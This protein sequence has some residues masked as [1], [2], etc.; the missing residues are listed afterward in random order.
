MT[1]AKLINHN[2]SPAISINGKVYPPMT[3]TITTCGVLGGLEGRI[4]DHDYF[5]ALGEAGIKIYYIMCNNLDLDKNAVSDFETEANFLLKAVPDAYIIVRFCLHPSEEWCK[6][7]PDEMVTYTDNR[8]IPTNLTA[9][10]C[11]LNLDGMPSLCSQKWRDEMGEVMLKTIKQIKAL[12]CSDHI[13]GYFLAGGGTSEWYYMNDIDFT[14]S[15]A[16]GDV[17]PAFKREFEGYLNEKYGNGV[18][19]PIIPNKEAR[20]YSEHIDTDLASPKIWN[21][22]MAEPKPPLNGTNHGVFVD[23]K[24]NQHTFDF[25][26]AWHLGTA[27]TIIHFAKLIKEN[28]PDT[29]VG[30]FFG[31][32]GSGEVIRGSNAIGVLKILDSGYVDFLANP[33]VYENRQPGGFTGQRQCP[34]SYR[35]R[36]AMFIVEDDTRTNA[37][38]AHHASNYY[39][40]TEND[41][42]NILKRDFGRNIC[43]DLQSWWFDQKIGG[44][45]YKS[46]TI[47]KLF[48]KQQEISQLAYSL[49]RRKNSEIAFIMDEES[50][51]AVS[52]QT[53]NE[54]IEQ[55]RSYD[56]AKIGAPIDSYFHNDLSDPN[57]PDYKLYIFA[58]CLYLSDK[59]R[60]E[61]KAKLRKNNA[62][63]VFLYAGGIINPD[64]ENKLDPKNMQDLLGFNCSEL[65]E[66]HRPLFRFTEG[67]HP[68]TENLDSAEFYGEFLKYRY[69]NENFVGEGYMRSRLLPMVYADDDSCTVLAR[70]LTNNKPA[71][72]YK[73]NDGYNTVYYGAKYINNDIV[74]EIARYA[75]CHIYEETGHVLH[76][77]NNFITLHAAH[78]GSVTIN[79]PK[80]CS[81]FEVY[82]E[83]YYGK[84]TNS[85]TFNIKKGETKMF[86][87]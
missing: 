60:E 83:K 52:K 58:N 56:I 55:F 41:S 61:I 3:A 68:I 74:R 28:F 81:L 8:K 34:D 27:N 72:A 13:V 78:S 25:Y 30:S 10:S 82:E 77:N 1:K 18:K 7:N 9:E 11:S 49:D 33:G 2:G 79:L 19:A 48:T 64:K 75:G 87:I 5:K 70:F 45:R 71:V 24:T 20:Y 53:T 43:E 69:T 29:L 50:L 47:Y 16:Y 31:G 44:Q 66:I 17:S 15:E 76:A 23:F 67:A 84:D 85:V 65:M 39:V 14:D 21:P 63:A 37:E 12:P 35:L 38:I 73:E 86:K 36:N 40:C 54:L 57:M 42:I 59:E 22:V 26:N 46:E 51:V 32:V 6:N 62:T 80:K 4:L